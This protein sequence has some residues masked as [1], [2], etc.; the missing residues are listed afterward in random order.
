MDKDA[1]R[2]TNR[3][4]NNAIS[5]AINDMEITIA[6]KDIKELYRMLKIYERK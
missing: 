1:V 3:S 6:Y 5:I 4:S 2:L